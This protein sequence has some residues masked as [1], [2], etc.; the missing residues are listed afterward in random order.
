MQLLVVFAAVAVALAALGL[1]GIIA[2]TVARR[3]REIGVRVALGALPRHVVQ[4]VASQGMRLV[5]CGIAFGLAGTLV[6][7]RL[8]QQFLF[9]V[10]PMDGPTLAAV[11]LVLGAAAGLACLLP[12]RRATRVQPMVALRHE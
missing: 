2:Y 9:D 4:M 5:A 1:Y 12:A 3:T 10:S 7:S 11:C 8:L 6:T